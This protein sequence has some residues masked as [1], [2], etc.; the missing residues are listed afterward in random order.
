MNE[1]EE[2]FAEKALAKMMPP[3]VDIENKLKQHFGIKDEADVQ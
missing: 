1:Q 2:T 3:K